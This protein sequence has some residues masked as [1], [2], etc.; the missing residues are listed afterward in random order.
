MSTRLSGGEMRERGAEL[1]LQAD[2]FD[3]DLA[4]HA[5]TAEHVA[6]LQGM[7]L[8]A[9]RVY[10]YFIAQVFFLSFAIILSGL[11]SCFFPFASFSRSTRCRVK[12]AHRSR[13]RPC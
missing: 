3:H 7:D 9:A 12:C 5:D 13:M 10:F 8:S 6:E 1:E 4:A 11:V 2:F